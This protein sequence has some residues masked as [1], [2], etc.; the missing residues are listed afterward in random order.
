MYNAQEGELFVGVMC[1]R[2]DASTRRRA[3]AQQ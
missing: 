2:V 3:D 1:Q